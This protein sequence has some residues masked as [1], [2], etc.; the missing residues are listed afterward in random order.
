[1]ADRSVWGCVGSNGSTIYSGTG[2]KVDRVGTGVYTVLF[3]V[4]FPQWPS[5]VATQ[6][7]PGN[8]SSTGG[9]TRDNAVVIA[10][11]TDRFRVTTGGSDGKQA[12]RDFSFIAMGPA[13]AA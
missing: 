13:P 3:D 12:D 1:M 11:S 5:V 6:M 8:M 4:A 7:Y 10:I 9:D 2:F